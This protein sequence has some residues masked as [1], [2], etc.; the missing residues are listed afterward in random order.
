M[1]LSSK[2]PGHQFYGKHVKKLWIEEASFESKT[3]HE[4]RQDALSELGAVLRLSGMTNFT[5]HSP[6]GK[7]FSEPKNRSKVINLPQYVNPFWDEEEKKK[8]LKEYGGEES[9]N[10]RVFVKGEVVKDGVSEFD[11]DRIKE[12]YQDQKEIKKFEIPKERFER[13]RDFIVVERPKNAER[14]FL[15]ADVGESAG[16]EIIIHSEVGEKYNYLYNITLYN[17]THNEQLEIF[18]WLIEK[19]QVN[20]IGIDCGDALGR[21]LADNLE[22]S[23]SKDNVVRYAGASKIAVGF[24][25]DKAGNQILKDGKPVFRKEYMSEWSVNR[26]KVLL[27]ETR[28]NI[29][30]DY[31]FDIQFTSVISMRSGTRIIYECVNEQAHLFDAWR[32]F[33]I[34]Q[35]LKKDFNQTQPIK[36]SWGTG[37]SSWVK[38]EKTKEK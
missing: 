29:P 12:C 19:L 7:A 6:A 3:V 4:K 34:S 22:K 18:K 36:K 1:N 2:N 8:R 24:E 25:K 11:M 38:K 10:Y 33:A 31:K 20:I 17:L 27:Y 37:A 14:I 28:C 32:V 9:I 21:T 5:E 15:D 35:W 26:L 23:Y 30:M 16:T 13:F